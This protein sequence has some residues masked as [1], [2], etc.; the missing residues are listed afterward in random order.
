MTIRDGT[1]TIEDVI[2]LLLDPYQPQLNREL[3]PMEHIESL[4]IMLAVALVE[5][6]KKP[7]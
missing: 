6:A 4:S 1:L 5:L 2:P 7:E 3:T